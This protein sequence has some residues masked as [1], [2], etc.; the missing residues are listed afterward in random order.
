MSDTPHLEHRVARGAAW[1]ALARW[2][3]LILT[4]GALVVLARMLGPHAWGVYAAAM[5]PILMIQPVFEGALGEG[6][7]RRRDLDR[8]HVDA[9]FWLG[10]TLAGVAFGVCTLAAPLLADGLNAPGAAALLP[11]L[12]ALLF[13][14]AAAVVPEA[15]LV[16]D[17][18]Q[19]PGAL[20]EIASAAAGSATGLIAA[21]LDAGVWSLVAMEAVRASVRLVWV[22]IAARWAPGFALRWSHVKDLAGFNAVGGALRFVAALDRVVPRIAIGAVLGQEALGYFALA[23]RVYDQ[24]SLLFVGPMNAMAFPA[25]ARAK[26]DPQQLRALLLRAARVSSLISYPAFIGLAV[27]APVF[28][29]LAFGA[30]WTAAAAAIQVLSLL[31][32]RTALASFNGGVLR[33]AD[34]AMWLLGQSI[35]GVALL[36]VLA[37]LAAPYGVTA[38]VGAMLVRSILTWPIS[39][40][41]VRRLLNVTGKDLAQAGSAALFA[42]LAMGAA[43]LALDSAVFSS[44][45]PPVRLVAMVGAGMVVY[46]GAVALIDRNIVPAIWRFAR[47]F[48]ARTS[49]RGAAE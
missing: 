5:V 4:V 9:A 27:V 19:R 34:R 29:P 21:A 36:A 45:S 3:N 15:L 37:P 10:V 42:S 32:L 35:L 43:V 6:I 17:L 22:A 2:L 24:V 28:V 33:G 8:G 13:L 25:A 1:V 18:R 7:V 49:A 38:V 23:M 16:R 12:A 14:S 44:W 11:P 41:G 40:W 46:G 39:V 47:G 20:A 48:A 31:G 30:E 26:S